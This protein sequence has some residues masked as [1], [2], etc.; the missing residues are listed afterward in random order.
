[1][2]ESHIK[3]IVNEKNLKHLALDQYEIK[4]F[5]GTDSKYFKQC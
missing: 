5:C 2:C 3:S 1:M 4:F